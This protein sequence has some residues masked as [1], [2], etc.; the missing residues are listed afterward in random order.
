MSQAPDVALD[1]RSVLEA[2]LHA[3]PPFIMK[4]LIGYAFNRTHDAARARDV[5]QEAVALVLAGNGWHRWRYDGHRKP[6][7]NLLLHLFDVAR[8]VVKNEDARAAEWREVEG[9]P[10]R[11]A[12]VSDGAPAPGEMPTEWAAHA[13]QERRAQ[14]VLERLDEKTREML[15]IESESEEQLDAEALGAKLGWTARQVYRARERVRHHRDVVLE[16]EQER[17][18][19]AS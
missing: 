12:Q 5:A 19:A 4:R 3:K 11:D 10:E 15:R 8:D 14:R 9:D 18:R 2:D 1:A 16:Q 17:G 13:Q 7:E 6:V